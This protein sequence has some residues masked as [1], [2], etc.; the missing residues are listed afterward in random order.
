MKNLPHRPTLRACLL[1]LRTGLRQPAANL[2]HFRQRM[3]EIAPLRPDLVCLP[4]CSF[5]GYLSEP[6]D[7]ARFAEP[8]PG[9]TTRQAAEVARQTGCYLCF[10]LL[11]A[12]SAGVYNTAVLLDRRGEIRLVHRKLTEQ[13]PFLNGETVAAAETEF[14]RLAILICGDLF[15]GEA[16]ARLPR[17]L[18]ALLLPMARCFDG[19]SPDAARWEREERQAYLDEVAKAGVA[20]LVVNALCDSPEE[21]SFGGALAVSADGAL[22][23][24][25]PHGS[26]QPL[27]VEM[28]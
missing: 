13:P 20:A 4:E 21:P 7:L 23:A 25:S 6:A 18:T 1:P 19:A 22:L 26:D 9:A 24:E 2:A 5:T 11:E 3:R 8:I 14:G 16:R 12:T 17:P 27:L 15:A 10:G 28:G